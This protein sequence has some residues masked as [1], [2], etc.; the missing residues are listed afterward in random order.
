MWESIKQGSKIAILGFGREGQATFEFFRRNGVPVTAVLDRAESLNSEARSILDDV[1]Y[2]GGEGYMD[3]LTEY[4]FIFRSPGVPRMHPKLMALPDQGAI[5]SHVKLFFDLCPCPII[6][7]TGTKGKTTT[8]SLIYEIIKSAGKIACLGGNIGLPPLEFLDKLTPESV[9]VLELSSFQT[10]DLHKSPHIGVILTVT[11]DHLDDG[12]FRPSSHSTQEEYM[13]AKAQLIANQ[14]P[15]DFAVLHPGLGDV[16]T[17]AGQGKKVFYD[18]AAAEAFET[19]LLGRH[20][21]ENIAAAASACSLFGVGDEVIRTAVANFSG[22]PQRLQ[23]VAEKNGIKYV[24]DSASTNPDSTSAAIDAF[25]SGV[26]LILGG[27]DKGLDY[28]DFGRKVIASPQ[29][30]ALVVIGQ[31]SPKILAAVNGFK[32]KVLTGAKDMGEIMEQANSLT[33][34]G[35]TVLLS[36]AA[37]SF[38]MFQ[39]SKDRGYKFDEAVSKL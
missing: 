19:K 1:P 6:A 21:L 31:V 36:P 35:D 8:T 20:N 22:V 39:N 34:P 18:A 38:D 11:S 25:D 13:Q 33:S 14:G 2:V 37:A 9:A 23:V 28:S 32:G 24:N 12:S 30:K 26:I 10:M 17:G 15:G 3:N 5:Y 7:V 27:S 4:D 16:F 29:I